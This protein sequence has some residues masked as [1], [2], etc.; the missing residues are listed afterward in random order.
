MSYIG[1]IDLENWVPTRLTNSDASLSI[2]AKLY[3]VSPESIVANN[4]TDW[5]SAAINKWVVDTGGKTMSS[6]ETAFTENSV[7]LLPAGGPRPL[8]AGVPR[9]IGPVPA[10]GTPEYEARKRAAIEEAKQKSIAK[11]IAA[12]G[13]MPGQGM[14]TQTKLLI[15]AGGVAAVAVA[16]V[17]L[18]K[19]KK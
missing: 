10:R 13:R 6:G 3:G 11:R 9:K 16:A 1:A 2:L 17:V 8:A 19:K 15:G 12:G 18:S 7:I 5:K 4:A 14:S